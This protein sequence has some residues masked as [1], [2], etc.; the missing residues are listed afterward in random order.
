MI[1]KRWLIPMILIFSVIFL[2][3]SICS[4]LDDE[5]S[6]RTLKGL[7]GIYVL[8]EELD[9]A[10]KE[11]GLTK[12]QIQTDVELK[13]R[14]AGIRILSEKELLTSPGL[15]SLYIAINAVKLDMIFA[16]DI[17]VGLDQYIKLT[18]NPLIISLAAT[19]STTGIG[20]VGETRVREN[21]R[22]KVKD[23]VD[24]FINAYLSVNPKK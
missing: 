19:W 3:T 4:A 15:P 6:R 18:R 11:R 21:I 9:P 24:K 5:F 1:N 17:Y 23:L 16:F 10:L 13:L 7:E 2:F 8:I 12:D 20:S 22:E 14:M